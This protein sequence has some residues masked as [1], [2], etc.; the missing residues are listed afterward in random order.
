MLHAKI[1]YKSDF[2]VEKFEDT[3]EVIWSYKSKERQCYE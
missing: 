3:K 2:P 1:Y